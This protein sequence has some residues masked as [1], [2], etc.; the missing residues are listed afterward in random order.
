MHLSFS[1]FILFNRK[2]TLTLG[3]KKHNKKSKKMKALK[4]NLIDK[5]GNELDAGFTIGTYN[6][7]TGFILHSR[8]QK[9]NS[10]YNQA[11]ELLLERLVMNEI[12]YVNIQVVSRELINTLGFNERR[13]LINKSC[14]IDLKGFSDIEI[15]INTLRIK[16]GKEQSKIK[17][18]QNSKGGNPTKRILITSPEIP[19]SGWLKFVRPSI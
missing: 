5:N 12:P 15:D 7:L 3:R 11:L 9:S 4:Q 2:L 13:I 8:S 18:N 10:E 19:E 1:D 17:V 6:N 16:I 14:N